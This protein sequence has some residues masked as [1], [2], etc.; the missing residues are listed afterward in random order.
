M[1]NNL[2][3]VEQSLR[4]I[5]KRY[6]N[7]KYSTGLVILFLMLGVNAFSE[8][9]TGMEFIEQSK[10]IRS[11]MKNSIGDMRSKI[12]SIKAENSKDLGN[13][14]LEL[15][16]L[17]EQGDQ[18]VKSPWASWQ[19]GVNYFYNNWRGTYEGKG[20]KD[21]KY[22]FSGRYDRSG[23][24]FLRNIHP[25]SKHYNDFTSSPESKQ[26]TSGFSAATSDSIRVF[27]KP[28]TITLNK[29]SATTS[30][31]G[32]D[33]DPYGLGKVR[34]RQEDIVKIELDIAVKIKNLK[35]VAVTAPTAVQPIGKVVSVRNVGTPTVKVPTIEN[36]LAS[37]IRPTVIKPSVAIPQEPGNPTSVRPTFTVTMFPTIPNL[38]EPD[39]I[40][41]DTS[42]VKILSYHSRVEEGKSLWDIEMARWTN[43]ANGAINSG[44]SY[45]HNQN[46]V[47]GN[48]DF[49]GTP[50][51]MYTS[52]KYYDYKGSFDRND[53]YDNALFKIWFDY[54]SKTKKYKASE[55]DGGGGTLTIGSGTSITIDSI[56][57]LDS[58][59]KDTE[60]NEFATDV[61]GAI[62]TQRFLV[63]GSR[64]GTLD[65]S[66]N[67][68]IENKGTVNL[69]GPLTLGFEVQT[70]TGGMNGNF[71]L[72]APGNSEG[73]DIPGNRK[74]INSGTIT[75]DI[76]STNAYRGSEGLGGLHVNTVNE[77][78]TALTNVTDSAK[79]NTPLVGF[80]GVNNEK[81]TVKRSSDIKK[82]DGSIIKGG[83][84][85]YK[86]GMILTAEDT[87]GN[88]DEN[89]S[90]SL[91]NKGIIRFNG[92]KSIGIQ[93]YAPSYMGSGHNIKVLVANEKGATIDLKGRN[94]YGMKLSSGVNYLNRFENKGTINISGI[95][96]NGSGS[97]GIAVIHDPLLSSKKRDVW[98]KETVD[99]IFASAEDDKGYIGVIRNTGNINVSGGTGNIGMLLSTRDDDVI[100]NDGT[101]SI[102]DNRNI[103]MK[104][105]AAG[106]HQ[107]GSKGGDGERGEFWPRITNK[108][109]INI[110][111]G[112]GNIGMLSTGDKG[113]AV[114]LNGASI[115][116]QGKKSVGMLVDSLPQMEGNP[117]KPSTIVNHGDI[118]T[119]ENK[120]N[121]GIIG[122]AIL[123]YSEAENTGKISLHAKGAIGVYN[124]GM[125]DGQDKESSFKMQDEY[126]INKIQNGWEKDK[127]GNYIL[128]KDGNKI[129]TYNYVNQGLNKIPEIVVSGENSIALYAR[130]SESKTYLERGKITFAGGVGLY[131]D[132]ASIK[133]G[134]AG[135]TNV[136]YRTNTISLTGGENSIMFYNYQHTKDA[137]YKVALSTPIANGQFILNNTVNATVKN[138]ASVFYMRGADA[139]NKAAFLNKMFT[140]TPNL[141]GEVSAAGKKVNLKM[142]EG[143]TLFITRNDNIANVVN[144]Q[145]LSTLTSGI[146][147]GNR[148]VIDSTSSNKYKIEKSIRN[149]M[150]VDI[151]VNLDDATNVYNRIEYL[152][153]W[154]TVNAGKKMTSSKDNKVGIFQTNLKREAGSTLTAPKVT[155]IQVV[156]AGNISL[157]GKK[158]IALATSFGQ[159]TNTGSISVTGESG[160]A[161][162]GADSSIIK[163][164]GSIEIGSK[165][166][167]IFAEND[168]KVN[169][170]STAISANK[171]LEIVNSGNIKSVANS[172]GTYG[173][174]AK[175]DKTTYK[176]ATATITNSG[177]INLSN[178][179][180]STGILI[181]N[182]SLTSSGNI[183]VGKNSIAV[184]TIKSNANLT[185]GT[186]TANSGTA[187]LA[188]NSTLNTN[189]NVNVRDNAIGINVKNSKVTINAGTYNVT[190]AI[191][192]KISSLGKS[193]FFKANAG[194]LN[195]GD[196]SIGFYFKNL[197]P[198][199]S[200]FVDKLTLNSTGKA[201]YI[202]ADN[203][204]L[205]YQNQ[206]VMNGTGSTF[207]YAKNSDITL[208]PNATFSSNG[209]N[210]T[211]IFSENI[212]NNKNIVN[213]GKIK[214][215]GENSVGIY[216][217]KLNNLDNAG[218][219]DLGLKGTGIYAKDTNL[220]KNTAIIKVGANGTGIFV[221]NS[222]LIN[223]N[224]IEAI[225]KAEKNVGIYAMGNKEVINS[226]NIKVTGNK[227][228]GIYSENSNIINTGNINAG[229]DSVGIY[230]KNINVGNNS[231]INVANGATAIYSKNA[232]VTLGNN[233]QIIAGNRSMGIH[234]AKVSVGAGSK[235]NING[236]G[237][238]IYSKNANT[239]LGN[240]VQIVAGNKSTGI[241]GNGVNI[242]L[243]SK[244]ILGMD[245][246]GI[247]SNNA[248]ITLGNNVQ[249]IAGNKSTGVYGKGVTIGTNSKISIGSEGT[250]IYSKDA[251]TV[252]GE[253]VQVN[254]GIKST[255]AY[256]SRVT[257]GKNSRVS[258]SNE[259]TAVYSRDVVATLGD[260]VQVIAG[261]KS[262]GVYGR[263]I[264]IGVGSK[265][266]IGSEGT[267]IYSNNSNVLLRNNVQ[268]VAG[269]KSTGVYGR[270]ISTGV[271]VKVSVG[272][273]STAVYSKDAAV[274]LGNGSQI[275]AGIKSTGVY[276]KGVTIGAGSK[277]SVSN[278]GTAIYAKDAIATLGDNIQ[279]NG[280][281]KSTGI[282]GDRVI[283]GKNS[284]IILGND[285][286]V[287]YSKNTVAT[288]GNNTQITAGIKSIGV[289][290][291]GVTIGIGSRITLRDN[292]TAIYSKDNNVILGANSQINLGSRATG[293]YGKAISLG[294][295]S[296]IS[297]G[298]YSTAIHSIGGTVELKAN[299]QLVAENNSTLIYYEGKN[300]NII[301]NAKLTLNDNSFG[302]T[303]KGL[304][305]RVQ[306]NTPGTV[307]LKNNSVF[308]YSSDTKGSVVNRTNLVSRGKGN[309][310]IYSAGK[311]D[312]YGTID[313]S[314]ATGSIAM[315]SFSPKSGRSGMGPSRPTVIP[316]ITNKA[317]SVIR[318]SKSIGSDYGVGM[319]AGN[320]ETDSNGNV[321][322][323]AVGHVVNEG[324]ISVTSGDSI[325]MYATGRGSIAENKG[326]IEISG[327]KRN[328]GMFLENGAVGNNYGTITTVGTNNKEQ[329]GIAVTSGA[330][331][332]N[333]GTIRLNAENGLGIYAF[334]GGIIRNRGRFILNDSSTDI[335]DTTAQ[336]DTSKKLGGVQIKVRE[337][338]RSEADILVNGNRKNPTLVHTIPNRAPNEIPTSS[339]GIYMS[340]SGLNP[341]TP[342]ENIG[343]L[344]KIGIKSADLIIGT[345]AAEYENT[346]YIKLGQDVIKPYNKM[347]KQAA[348]KINKWEIYS[349]SLT[350]QATVT[351]KST[352]H[353][354]QNAYMAKTPYTFYA[355][356]KDTTRDTYNFADGLEQRYGVEKV[357]TREKALFN[358]LNNIGN[359]EG[360]L[361]KQAFDEM[362]GHQYANLSQRVRST[363]DILDKE[364][365][366]LRKDWATASKNSNK[367]KTF[368][369]RGE[370]KTNTAGVLDYTNNASG[371]VYVFENEDIRLGRGFGYYTGIVHNIY[372]FKDIGRSK[373]E[374]LQTKIGAFKSIPFDE[375]NS[376][377]WTISGDISYG[378]NKMNRKFLV[379]ED[380]FNAKGRYNTYG[381]A[382]KNEIGKDFR[383]TERI[384][385]KPYT[386]IKVEY[387]KIGKV[388]EKSGEVRLDVKDSYY[389]SVKPELGVE[390][391]YK[392]T[393]G[394][395]RIITAR[396]GTVYE[397]EVGKVAK[398]ENKAR[399]AYTTADWFNL[400][401]EKED[402]KGNI[403][404][405]LSLGIEGEILGGT[406]NIGYDTKGKNIR[407]GVGVRIIF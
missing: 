86:V 164:T 74:I 11:E 111:G 124:S 40:S 397:N 318:V 159:L 368:G 136:D 15:I 102:R 125:S 341:T 84:T 396:I 205:N 245:S 351:Q 19:F 211:G 274:V 295:N 269:N 62:N 112:T 199:S 71:A 308:I 309:Y 282:Y 224:N 360:I 294:A 137:D 238:A 376:F 126:V 389:V 221:S 133:I 375:N 78:G 290:G 145:K 227:S 163:N 61:G 30:S 310:G 329:I 131:A 46:K 16:Q 398:A 407:G 369:S 275:I 223:N 115:N 338:N 374:M 344:A 49:K 335:K 150:T 303:I 339:V 6:K 297:T 333:F 249:I 304:N 148:V 332:N 4:S 154:V 272:V 10:T 342:I 201:V 92:E 177:N 259:S 273:D 285:S 288:L 187:V 271:G 65:N 147:L 296:K 63:G 403:R 140:D 25:D 134:K 122:M 367:V 99:P 325:G 22:P 225:G 138:G 311:V 395:G 313:F 196:N 343:A 34:I 76:E 334:G 379:V 365:T 208:N 70:D 184:N 155:D 264:T 127:S 189:A 372:K 132:R 59:A 322:Q 3:K 77:N 340:S 337:D 167:A 305:N 42:N 336:A 192:F 257:I 109:N 188:N 382:L 302:I 253:A 240:N 267:A 256:G 146:P 191:A 260:N 75:D 156:N 117:F 222:K 323:T 57:T 213:R 207:I 38:Y 67:A 283:V 21:E 203:S 161:L 262:T 312:N 401:K 266:N 237:T 406:A 172:V 60:T 190:K 5:A 279:V 212:T 293:I 345:E 278:E 2:H 181:E 347:L 107:T 356:D 193:D 400:P 90:Y 404:T 56:N 370:Y 350:W 202:Y 81:I 129:A 366:H 13:S 281:I 327:N 349:S 96:K 88:Y 95:D 104:I 20:D 87:E 330:I 352:D 247:Y 47:L 27:S 93:I 35:R 198:T 399:I 216:A 105:Y 7:I 326:T 83:Y 364:F 152:S 69:V 1:N 18:V 31:R 182:G 291:K 317:G 17:M 173:I 175:N 162:Y 139:N 110:I 106:Y 165:G 121:E 261:N 315:F 348:G 250:A 258:V 234:G 168:L 118:K 268:V 50:A 200:N 241:Y 55:G 91:I 143:S 23:N 157:R 292:S 135:A 206:K 232:T 287:V 277:I 210:I 209:K 380:I 85:G 52:N 254:A 160:V 381:V 353:T 45:D 79:I 244:I 246:I 37:P 276:G 72:R 144:P 230:G 270:G 391:N 307:T 44:K 66:T 54:G 385:I 98:D 362:M 300:G 186:I 39:Y 176:N 220:V 233:V 231:K 149:K 357:G 123:S 239:I 153:S 228:I 286:T 387:G 226:A 8:E 346:K 82:R 103:G 252:L 116:I 204:I 169:N 265:V 108:K 178:S 28:T 197:N 64:V 371:V 355:D 214:L 29:T 242:G 236:E 174:F 394:S 48:N 128:D 314:K 89:S 306:N 170:V 194:T 388:R 405:D 243:G 94:S 363:G 331:V 53:N 158:S 358:Q 100:T 373:E 113:T 384:S 179:T 359:N 361:L 402:K 120:N 142:E 166:A 68:T 251:N 217:E 280:G 185:S 73:Y 378:Y 320:T 97:A 248:P 299:S 14:R 41:T 298:A 219:L 51:L 180:S 9:V 171:N 390:A 141:K 33:K 58:N 114:N 80:D 101:I 24:L 218:T 229:N 354:I 321:I 392:Y 183:S 284:K 386:A 255:G 328:I 26:R 301:N 377:N 393:L 289:Y 32:G 316:T 324:K 151:D 43:G 319:V 12:E 195:L 119:V 130:G 235:I 263:G 383:L 36:V 215:L